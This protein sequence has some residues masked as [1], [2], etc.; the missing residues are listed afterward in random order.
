MDAA[1]AFEQ[2]HEGAIYLHQGE[3]YRVARLDLATRT[4]VVEPDDGGYYTEARVLTDLTIEHVRDTRSLG[5][6]TVH[7]GE[8]RVTQQVVEFRRKQLQT[9][10]V[11]TT[12]PLEMPAQELRTVALWMVLPD[13]LAGAV[14]AEGRDFAGGIHAIEHAA[15]GL[16]PLLTMC[17]RWD[18]GGVSY[19]RHPETGRPTIF[20]YDGY[21]GG[22]GV[23]EQGFRLLDDLLARTLD[24]IEGC[25]CEAGCPS[26]VQSPKCGNLNSPL[27]KHAAE[28]LLR[29]LLHTRTAPAA[30]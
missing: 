19:P 30:R 27:D 1:R 29:R 18:I 28:L 23:T 22:V 21:P 7:V 11:L 4:A 16:L 9:D 14:E 10:T 26:C 25:P 12:Q 20:I 2:V 13:E 3:A 5:A 15:I 8:V 24:A 17:D 6:A